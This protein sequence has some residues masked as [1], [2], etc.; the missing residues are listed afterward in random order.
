MR[1]GDGALAPKSA[2]PSHLITNKVSLSVRS[3]REDQFKQR[4]GVSTPLAVAIFRFYK[5]VTCYHMVVHSVCRAASG[6]ERVQMDGQIEHP[7]VIKLE[8]FVFSGP[9]PKNSTNANEI[10]VKHLKRIAPPLTALTVHAIW[11]KIK[12]WV[13]VGF[14]QFSP[15]GQDMGGNI[16]NFGPLT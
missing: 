4:Q 5:D 16:P 10:G 12:L 7:C 13:P 11:L 2:K 9:M 3:L 8:G 1:G 14:I 15:L 6:E